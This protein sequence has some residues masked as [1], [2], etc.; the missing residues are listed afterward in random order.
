M[1]RPGFDFL[2]LVVIAL[3]AIGTSSCDGTYEVE[4]RVVYISEFENSA[5][6]I[7]DI[8]GQPVPS[9]GDP[10]TD[11][12]VTM[13]FQLDKDKKPVEG[14]IWQSEVKTDARGNFKIFDVGAPGLYP[15]LGL[16]V[17]KDGYKGIYT[18]FVYNTENN[19]D[20]IQTFYIVLAKS[21]TTH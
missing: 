5:G 10:L 20:K 19:R 15:V 17:T 3:L 7:A 1:K 21:S 14:T 12:S 18:T 9:V 6:I 16:Q 2:A 8:T 13:Y 4:G 11:A